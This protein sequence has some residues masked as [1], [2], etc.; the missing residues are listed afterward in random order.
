M[1]W[2]VS[3]RDPQDYAAVALIRSFP[4]GSVAPDCFSPR[5][6]TV[7]AGMPT[8]PLAVRR[9]RY[10]WTVASIVWRVY[11]RAC[12]DL[13][14]PSASAPAGSWGWQRWPS[15]DSRGFEAPGAPG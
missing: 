8:S 13:R 3:G 5:R 15:P 14:R 9:A 10:F 11:G 12:F 1:C 6:G 2:S 7:A 4:F